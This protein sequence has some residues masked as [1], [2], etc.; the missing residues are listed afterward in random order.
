M[1]TTSKPRKAGFTF[2]SSGSGAYIE[3]LDVAAFYA[4]RVTVSELVRM[5]LRHYIATTDLF[6]EE[7]K[8]EFAEVDSIE[9]LK[10]NKRHARFNRERKALEMAETERLRK[11]LFG[12]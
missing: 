3:K 8:S 1:T 2:S 11:E 9:R 4:G 7:F 5:A 10:L 12:K 6:N